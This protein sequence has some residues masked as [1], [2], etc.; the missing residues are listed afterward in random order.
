[1]SGIFFLC[2]RVWFFLFSAITFLTFFFSTITCLNLSFTVIMCLTFSFSAN[3]SSVHL[4]FS[5]RQLS[6]RPINVTEAQLHC[7]IA[8]LIHFLNSC[9][10]SLYIWNYIGTQ[11]ILTL[12][13]HASTLQCI[14]SPHCV[15]PRCFFFY[16]REPEIVSYR[17]IGLV[18]E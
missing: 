1:M 18:I 5:L 4:F 7:I 3:L 12:G 9:C 2:P 16:C 15:T 17:N 14:C 13:R 8:L 6:S 11:K 10:L